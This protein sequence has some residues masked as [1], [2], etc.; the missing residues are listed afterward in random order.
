M[1]TRRNVLAMLAAGAIAPAA[2]AHTMFNQWVVYRKKHL[3]IGSHRRDLKTYELALEVVMAMDHLLPEASARAA[4]APHAERLASLL[5]TGQLDLA[6]VTASDAEQMTLGVADFE[7]YGAIPLTLVANLRSHLFLAH[8]DFPDHHAWLVTA[9]LND[10]GLG[11]GSGEPPFDI[12]FH[13]GTAAFRDGVPVESL[14][15]R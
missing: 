5:G 3:L 4:R 8:R 13:P 15:T 10:I 6:I 11:Y 14:P 9:V 12:A 2:D 7:P 1:Q